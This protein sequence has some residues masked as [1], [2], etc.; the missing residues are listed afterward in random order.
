MIGEQLDRGIQFR[1]LADCPTHDIEGVPPAEHD[2]TLARKPGGNPPCDVNRRV[3]ARLKEG[4]PRARDQIFANGDCA[5]HRFGFFSPCYEQTSLI[6]TTNLPFT[7]WPQVF[8]ED[9]RLARGLLDRLTHHVHILEIVADSY[10]L[11]SSLEK[12]KQKQ[13]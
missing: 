5:E 9:E 1:D 7:D 10:R 11:R 3:C 6:V 8:A 4:C 2:K 13:E 12:G